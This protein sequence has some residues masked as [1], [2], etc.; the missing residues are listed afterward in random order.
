MTGLGKLPYAALK[1]PLFHRC[2]AGAEQTVP[3]VELETVIAKIAKIA[4]IAKIE[5]QKSQ[6]LITDDTD[7]RIEIARTFC[8]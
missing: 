2:S 4:G 1:G 8:G 5:E 6:N 7:R 3:R